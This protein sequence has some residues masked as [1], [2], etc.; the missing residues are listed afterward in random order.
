VEIQLAITQLLDVKTLLSLSL[1]SRHNH[2]LCLPAI[3]NVRWLILSSPLIMLICRSQSVTLS[4]LARLKHFVD[5]VPVDHALHIR[6][7]DISAAGTEAA[8]SDALT[9]ILSLAP[10]L[11]TLSLRL[12]TELSPPAVSSFSKLEQLTDLAIEPCRDAIH[13]SL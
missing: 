6:S 12:S 5:H 13:S 8:S 9:R 1:V 3:Y 7:L 2:A 10:R 11:R 4:S